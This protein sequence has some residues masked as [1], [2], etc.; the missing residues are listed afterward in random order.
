MH[1]GRTYEVSKNDEGES[2]KYEYRIGNG[3]ITADSQ[4]KH[5]LNEDEKQQL[6]NAVFS[7][8]GW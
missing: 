1:Q 8:S 5:Q 3:E 4:D 6:Y 2:Y 7:A